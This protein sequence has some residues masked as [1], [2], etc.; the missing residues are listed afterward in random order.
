M[1]AADRVQPDHVMVSG[2]PDG[3]RGGSTSLH[4]LLATLLI[5]ANKADCTQGTWTGRLAW[6]LLP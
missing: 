4:W 1:E 3:R 5:R 6:G 2:K